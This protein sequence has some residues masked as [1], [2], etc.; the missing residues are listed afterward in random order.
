MLC[1][2]YKNVVKKLYEKIGL[3]KIYIKGQD[4]FM[5]KELYNFVVER[6]HHIYR[7]NISLFFNKSMTVKERM[8]YR[9]EKICEEETPVIL[10]GELICFIRTI[11]NIPDIFSEEEW[12]D[13]KLKHYIH[14]SGY[15]SNLSPDYERV[16]SVGLL[17]IRKNADE[18]GKR[19]I[20]AIIGLADRYREEAIRQGRTDIA[21]VLGHI[22]RYGAENFREALQF[23]RIIHYALWLEGNYHNTIG[24]FDKYMYPYFQKDME[25]GIYTQESVLDLLEDFFL[26]F[27]KDSD[28]YVGVQQGDNGQSMVLGGVDENGNEVFNSLSRLC[29]KASGNLLMIDP[30]INLRVNKN[31]PIEIY[32]LGSELTKAGLGFPQYSNDDIVID[33]LTKLGYELEDARDYVVAACWEFIIP[34]VGADVANIAALSFPKIINTCLY[35]D[36]QNSSTFSEFMKAVKSEI[37]AE[38]DN[39]CDKIKDLWFVPSPFMNSL[40]EGGIYNGAKYNNFGIHGTGIATAAD[41]LAVIKKYVFM[42]KFIT[43]EDLIE[44]VSS[45]FE[46]HSEILPILRYEAPKMGNNEQLPDSMAVSLL[47]AFS[48]ALKGKTNC[49]NGIYRAGTGSAMYYLWHAEEI[50]ASPDGRRR[51]EPFGTNFSPSLFAKINGPLSVIQS[52]SKPDFSK[53]INGGPLTLEFAASMFNDKESIKKIAAFVK[54]FIDMGGHQLQLNAVN[55]KLMEDAQRNP[56]RHRQLVVRIWGWSAYFVELDKAYQDHVMRR[57]QY[58]A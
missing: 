11:K 9:F 44:A 3:S 12:R 29:L 17:E 37:Q 43:K 14:E 48:E 54:A 25:N 55:S 7:K 57:Q 32:K 20:D 4:D 26:S 56:E 28:L 41:S 22:P 24:R 47:D 15:M 35:R 23:F 19:V 21:E 50:G 18:Y 46:K 31:T 8:A 51:G 53:V 6:R 5:N 58:N 40:F 36:L 33:G 42:D 1:Y 13:I 16:I 34:K 39:I 10:E 52:F 2:H 30:K 38:C 45:D 27:N 49:R